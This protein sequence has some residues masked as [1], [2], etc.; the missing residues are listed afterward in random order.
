MSKKIEYI[1]ANGNH[2]PAKY[3]TAH[4]KKRDAAA[5]KIYA[6][7]QAEQQR[8]IALRQKTD[9]IID[10]ILADAQ[11]DAGVEVDRKIGN[12]QFRSFDGSLI[13]CRDV[14]RVKELG[15]QLAIIQQLIMEAIN[16]MAEGARSA[17]IAS[18]AKAAFT[19]RRSGR[20]DMQ[21]I[22]DLVKIKVSHP[23]WKKAVSLL[24]LAE[25]DIGS[26]TYVRVSKV[27]RS[28]TT[29]RINPLWLNMAKLPDG[30]GTQ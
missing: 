29:S 26:R 24:A 20:L 13:I 3:V 8:L 6:L 4:E 2:V 30:G 5:K 1:D 7:W 14:Q 11:A 12:V 18:I 21:R 16:E 10:D 9:A 25:R 27:T 28:G 19:P 17:D 23:K 22:R 15:E